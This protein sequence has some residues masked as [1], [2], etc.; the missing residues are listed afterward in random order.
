[1]D[2]S[3]SRLK[4]AARQGMVSLALAGALAGN[5][6]ATEPVVS[7]A[8]TP[9]RFTHEFIDDV[10]G[11]NPPRNEFE[12]G[13]TYR[14]NIW[15]EVNS[16][17]PL[18]AIDLTTVIPPEV[19]FILPFVPNPYLGTNDLFFGRKMDSAANEVYE[20]LDNPQRHKG[21]L[22]SVSYT[23]DPADEQ[24][25]AQ[26]IRRGK[27]IV[28]SFRVFAPFFAERYQS[29]RFSLTS[30]YVYRDN[31]WTLDWK[32]RS[33]NVALL[34]Y[35]G[36][37]YF[38]VPR[39][40]DASTPSN[41]G[42]ERM[43]ILVSSRGLP[44]VLDKL[45]GNLQIAG[46]NAWSPVWTNT[47]GVSKSY[48]DPVPWDRNNPVYYRARPYRGPSLNNVLSSPSLRHRERLCAPSGL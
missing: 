18:V 20:V 23:Y 35:S 2:L 47:S 38:L 4:R 1:M 3:F 14:W 45:T 28:A 42:N 22:R 15:A 12:S 7:E 9:V 36:T 48:A 33:E 29:A 16:P 24:E 27:G 39:M 31:N 25:P 37:N 6:S 26:G 40:T 30:A 5:V 41:D 10:I 34:K 21:V 46:K 43:E 19:T 8:S 13:L 32:Q 17:D 44:C 11:E